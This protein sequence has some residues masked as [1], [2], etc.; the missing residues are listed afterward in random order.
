MSGETGPETVECQ[1]C[2]ARIRKQASVCH[3]CG[4]ENELKPGRTQRVSRNR[5]STDYREGMLGDAL[6]Y[7]V[8]GDNA[9][10]TIL[11]GG[12][13]SLL[14]IFIV[15]ILFVFGFYLRVL[16]RTV[17]DDPLPPRFDEWGDLGV[18]GFFAFLITV[19]YYLI[20]IIVF[21]IFGGL[22][23][24]SGSE[25]VAG[26]GVSIGLIV[27]FLLFV[28]LTY[29]Y[30]AAI[31]NFAKTGE[32]GSAFEVDEITSIV[33]SGDYLAAW[34]LGF[35]IFIV[36]FVLLLFLGIIPIIGQLVGLFV[37]FYI[38]MAAYRIFG[39]AFRRASADSVSI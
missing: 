10:V 1:S 5:E 24:L 32:I 8:R 15:P 19:A 25:S 2:G 14:S 21:V 17:E 18:N 28:G 29:I 22:G 37:N 31:T 38:L 30:P 36:G 16:K 39:T 7:P 33:K 9:L 3:Q 23:G 6:E 13:L 4:V 11:I 12:V 34:L 26:L 20:P 35:L 27:G